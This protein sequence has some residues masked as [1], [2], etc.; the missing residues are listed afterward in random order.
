[1]D[2]I[3]RVG[4]YIRIGKGL[5]AIEGFD[6]SLP[7]LKI[8]RNGKEIRFYR[9]SSLYFNAKLTDDDKKYLK[10]LAQIS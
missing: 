9:G 4:R 6:G 5:T 7:T 2:D 8:K 1:M 3:K 10:Q